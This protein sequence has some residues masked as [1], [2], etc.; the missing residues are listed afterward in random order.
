MTCYMSPMSYKGIPLTTVGC[1]AV[2]ALSVPETG[3]ADDH[4]TRVVV[5]TPNKIEFPQTHAWNDFLAWSALQGRIKSW[6]DLPS[7][8]DGLEAATPSGATVSAATS[9]MA[10]ARDRRLPLPQPFIAADGEIG[11][12]WAKGNSF[13]SVSFLDDGS[14]VGIVRDSGRVI[15]EFDQPADNA[16]ADEVFSSLSRFG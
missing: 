9:F 5:T 2:L 7:G 14:V 13:A 6:A 10:T 4:A 1:M 11:F 16:V 3:A 8:W 15:I 12:R